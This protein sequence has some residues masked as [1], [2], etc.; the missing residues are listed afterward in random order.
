MRTYDTTET[1]QHSDYGCLTLLNMDDSTQALQVCP[2]NMHTHYLFRSRTKE[3]YGPI[4][5]Q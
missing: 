3:V 5:P 2:I 1:K 4:H